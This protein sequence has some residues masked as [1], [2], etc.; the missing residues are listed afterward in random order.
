MTF[1]VR[2]MLDATE[3]PAGTM[4]KKFDQALSVVQDSSSQQQYNSKRA[5]GCVG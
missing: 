2:P 5:W 1:D 3:A 4:R